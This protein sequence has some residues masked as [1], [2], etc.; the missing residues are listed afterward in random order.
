V[1]E[2]L[3]LLLLLTQGSGWLL[4]GCYML[5]RELKLFKIASKSFW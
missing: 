4:C 3:L 5:P 2:R 1:L